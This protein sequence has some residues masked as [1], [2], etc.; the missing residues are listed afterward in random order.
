MAYKGITLGLDKTSEPYTVGINVD[1]IWYKFSTIPGDVSTTVQ[2]AFLNVRLFGAVGDGVADD[3]AAIAAADAVAVTNGQ[4]LL[5]DGPAYIGS[6]LTINSPVVFG[7]LGKIITKSAATTVTLANG[8]YAG[9]RQYVFNTTAGGFVWATN[10]DAASINQY[11]FGAVGD[12]VADDTIPLQR[13]VDNALYFNQ[14]E[15]ASWAAGTHR[16]TSPIFLNYG[17]TF[18]NVRL[19]GAGKKYGASSLVFLGTRIISDHW[20][21]C[22]EIQGARGN[23]VSGISFV[24]PC[25]GH[26]TD[27]GPPLGLWQGVATIADPSVYDY[28][29]V[30]TYRPNGTHPNPLFPNAGATAPKYIFNR[31]T[32]NAAIHVDPRCGVKPTV[33]AKPDARL[34]VVSGDPTAA[35]GWE[36]GDV[37]QGV[38]LATN[39]R[40]LF[41]LPYDRLGYPGDP[42]NGVYVVQAAGAPVRATDLDAAAE[43]DKAAVAIAEGTYATTQWVCE[44]IT[45]GLALGTSNIVFQEYAGVYA[46][47]DVTYPAYSGVAAQYGRAL[48]SEVLVDDC[49]IEGFGCAFA[50][51]GCD[52]D[53]NADYMRLRD[54]TLQY[55]LYGFAWGN[56]QARLFEATST[57]ITGSFAI[58]TNKRI[59]RQNGR[60]ALLTEN[61]EVAGSLRILDMNANGGVELNQCYGEGGCI[62]GTCSNSS[63]PQQV[64]IIG[65]NI[66][67]LQLLNWGRYPP[68]WV[69]VTGSGL[70]M[71]GFL[72]GATEIPLIIKGESQVCDLDF[73]AVNVIWPTGVSNPATISAADSIARLSTADVFFIST[74]AAQGPWRGGCTNVQ[75]T[76]A[77]ATRNNVRMGPAARSN[78]GL[79]IPFCARSVSPSGSGAAPYNRVDPTPVHLGGATYQNTIGGASLTLPSY[80]GAKTFEI[81]FG[82]ALSK[83]VAQNN[84]F[85]PG[86]IALDTTTGNLFVIQTR[87]ATLITFKQLNNMDPN[88]VP[89]WPS[90]NPN[91]MY[92][93]PTGHYTPSF[94]L[95]LTYTAASATVTFA[96]A[97]GTTT[98]NAQ[99][100]VDAAKSVQDALSSMTPVL[101]AN[102]AITVSVAGTITLAGNARRN[103]TEDA[104]IWLI[105]R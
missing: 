51:K 31:F 45:G 95:E 30:T 63:N 8:F 20:G 16:T 1:G 94:G 23:R 90:V 68:Y 76:V 79:P 26:F 70:V 39:D 6:G 12:G 38:T 18:A 17:A 62:L 84:G 3:W 49:K 2:D 81:T 27:E 98:D 35:T 85:E 48:S 74:N 59:G 29:D 33:N 92:F 55:N 100:P 99:L 43:F 5:I 82:A 7:P 15:N 61:S 50:V 96:R 83:S 19:I 46:Y 41:A 65:G 97:D 10:M 42:R 44:T 105:P 34:A 4:K 60:G 67:A 69:D 103:T 25:I 93:I 88:G 56:T 57:N 87:V 52:A 80:T 36:D 72:P 24:G 89:Y 53:G 86:C 71:K 77:G 75:Y 21:N 73:T 37:V 91:A 102:S 104:G 22:I 9:S 54:S 78:V 11:N 47:S 14:T 101:A 64:V 66:G 13:V 40:I 32:I 58:F 28:W